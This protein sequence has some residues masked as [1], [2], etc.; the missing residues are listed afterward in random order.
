MNVF[1]TLCLLTAVANMGGNL[2]LVAFQ[3]PLF[4]RLGIPQP[5]DPRGFVLESVL[6]FTMGVVALLI[7]LRPRIG[8]LQVAI[9]GKGAYALVTYY[10]FATHGTHPFYLVFAA[11]D[12]AYVAIFFLYWIHLESPDL[13]R[14]AVETRGGIGRRTD[15]AAIVGF[16]LTGNGR[17]AIAELEEGL[18]RGG[19]R[20]DVLPVKAVEPIF[21]FPMSLGDFVRIVVR[22]FFR[23]P[24]QVWPLEAPR[25]DYDLVVVESP[26]WLLGMA[27]PVEAVFEN[28]ANRWLFEGRDVAALVVCRGAHRRTRTMMVRWLEALGANIVAARGFAHFGWEPLRL[29]S[30]WL[31]LIYR[32]AP[33]YGLDDRTL[34]GIRRMG[35]E[36]AAR[37]RVPAPEEAHV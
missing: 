25:R 3:R 10:F 13:P 12:A 17:K 26:T 28:P 23:I 21:R 4:E 11:W 18:R 33:S 30:L 34:A 15:Y 22:A 1:R 32:K 36:L 2:L 37:S 29:L 8:L 6:S 5:V 19:Y 16:S 24:A 27:A 14:L 35:E 20:V 7:F 9:V 31:Y